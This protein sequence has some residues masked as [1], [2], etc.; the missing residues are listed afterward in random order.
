MK[1]LVKTQ[2]LL[3]K[4]LKE[5]I[6]TDYALV[7]GFGNDEWMYTSENVDINTYFDAASVGKVFPT[8][9]LVLQAIS[10][11]L[12]SLEDTLEKFFLN[13]PDD[14]KLITIKQLL[15]HTS[16]II[17]NEFPENVADRG[18]ESIIEFILRQ[19]VAF[20][21]EEYYAYSCNAMLLL[22]FIVEKVYGMTLN[23]AFQKYI[24]EPLGMTRSKYNIEND[25]ENAAIC[26]SH[27][28]TLEHPWDD[29]NVRKMKGIPAGSGGNFC[30]AGDLQKFVKALLNKDERLYSKE[31]FDLAEQNHTAN[32]EPWSEYYVYGNHGFG[33]EYVDNKCPQANVLFPEGSVGKEGWTGQSFYFNRQKNLY[34]ILLTNA[35]RCNALKHGG[36]KYNEI[37]TMRQEIHKAIK[38][39]LSI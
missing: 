34:V 6:F 8:S 30:T 38:E 11:G 21:P 18:R 14:K 24:I 31:L 17:R 4:N 29:N 27:S 2:K 3:E 16:G 7:V 25:E 35:T 32:I 9:T 5:N 23:R 15:T 28:L 20:K 33:Y 12:L 19:P 39:D 10:K 13:V 26:Y 1:L 37:C 36:V 22:G